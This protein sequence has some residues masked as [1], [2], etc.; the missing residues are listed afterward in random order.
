MA[1]RR[2]FGITLHLLLVAGLVLP[3]IAAPAQAASQ[4][5][6]FA[7]GTPGAMTHASCD[8]MSM[9]DHVPAKMPHG[10]QH[11]CDLAACL[12]SGC[13]PALPHVAAFVPD[14]EA[15]MTLDQPVPP[16]QLPDTPLRPPIA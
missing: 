8:G 3:G 16:S 10:A 12:G 7:S 1:F 13:L 6:A 4:A 14:A 15:P 5:L 11:G 2:F 9:N